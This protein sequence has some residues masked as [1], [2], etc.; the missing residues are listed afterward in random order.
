MSK[1]HDLKIL[2]DQTWKALEVFELDPSDTRNVI[3]FERLTKILMSLDKQ[4]MATIKPK[5]V[6]NDLDHF[7]SGANDR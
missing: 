6:P 5:E 2:R 1:V 4:L 7:L 3:R